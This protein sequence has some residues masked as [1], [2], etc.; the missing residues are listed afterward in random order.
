MSVTL[1]GCRRSNFLDYWRV[2]SV[3]VSAC[4]V[5]RVGGGVSVRVVQGLVKGNDSYWCIKE[6]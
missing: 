5:G 3:G 1:T 6:I 2:T 4:E